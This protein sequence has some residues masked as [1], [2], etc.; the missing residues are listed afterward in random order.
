ME[1]R[2]KKIYSKIAN[3]FDLIIIFGFIIAGIIVFGL[4]IS[5]TLQVAVL[6]FIIS[7]VASYP[8]ISD[9]VEKLYTEDRTRLISLNIATDDI[10][11]YLLKKQAM[12]NLEVEGRLYSITTGDGDLYVARNY[13]P[14]ENKAEGVWIADLS[15]IQLLQYKEKIDEA[16]TTLEQE[17]RKGLAQRVRIRSI[18][19]RTV[20]KIIS[21]IL[22]DFERST[23]IKGEEIEKTVKE[24]IENIN[25]SVED[26]EF[27]AEDEE[28]QKLNH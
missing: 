4:D 9:W 16:Q 5:I 10:N 27:D 19:H 8:F 25:E 3:N 6:F 23:L 14:E 1:A 22:K 13:N 15:P 2:K 28:N 18:V 7:L 26:F 20:T 11:S 17:A 24:E 12:N 21:K